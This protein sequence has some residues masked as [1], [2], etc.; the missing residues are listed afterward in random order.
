MPQTTGLARQPAR[1]GAPPPQA[2]TPTPTQTQTPAQPL[3]DLKSRQRAAWASCDYGVI[4]VTLQIVGEQLC[5][6]IDLRAGER[7]LDVAAGNG[8][9]SLAAARRF[10]RVTATDYVEGLLAGAQRRAAA[11]GLALQCQVA[12]AEALPFADG[13]F[14]V[15][16]STFGVMFAPD[17]SQAAREMLRVTRPAGRIGLANW[18]PEGFI[19]ELLRTIGRRVPAAAG[20]PAPTLWGTPSRIGEWFG[21]DAAGIRMERRYFMF[22]YASPEHWM[23]QFQAYYGPLRKAFEALGAQG[24]QA[25]QALRSDLLDLLQR[26]NRGGAGSLLIPGEY[27]EVVVDRR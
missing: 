5:E 1:D 21:S 27:L 16:L 13:S 3:G 26:A 14:D 11:D 4:G 15:S 24:P 2:Q 18:T 9:A 8:N 19:G 17:Q 23:T 25:G 6:A 12:D 22:R 20:Q 10:A 7:V